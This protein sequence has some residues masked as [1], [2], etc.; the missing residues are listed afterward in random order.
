LRLVVNRGLSFFGFL[1]LLALMLGLAVY[2][3]PAALAHA[4]YERS[5][6]AANATVPSGQS[7]AQ[8]QVWFTEDLEMRFSE[9]QVVD[10]NKQRVDTGSTRADPTDPRSMII[11]LKP[12]LP[13]GAYTV[14]YNNAS[15]EDG[16]VLKGNFSFLVGSGTLPTSTA[17][18]PLEQAEGG[19]TAGNENANPASITLRW[20]NYLAAAALLGA[21]VF[22][23]LIW[24]PAVNRAR[25]TKRMGPELAQANE[26]GLQ[27]VLRV[28]W[29]GLAAMTVG[30][31]AWWI[32]QAATLS[33]Q[34]LGQLFGLGGGSSGPAALADFLFNTRYGLIWFVRL[35]LLIGVL[36]ALTFM[37]RGD[38]R[39]TWLDFLPGLRQGRQNLLPAEEANQAV[40]PASP[41]TTGETIEEAAETGPQ[42]PL[43]ISL[44]TRRYLWWAG[45]LYGMALMLTTSLNSHAAAVADWGFW[46]AIASDWLHLLSTATWVGGL[47]AMSFALMVALPALR[48]GSGDRTR[49]LAS[50]IP[51]FSQVIIISVMVLLVTGTFNAALQLANVTDLFSTPYGLS[52]TLKITLLV[53]LLLLGA[54][55]LLVVSPR[56]RAFARSKKAGPQEGAGSIAAGMLGLK[57]RRAVWAEIVLTVLILLVTAFLTSSNPPK[58]LATNNVLYFQT[59]QGDL[60]IDLAIAPGTIGENTFEVRLTDAVTNQP[61]SDA[62]LV[63]LR[64][65]MQEMDMGLTNLELKPLNGLPGRYLGEGPALAMVGTWHADLLI[66]RNG[67]DDV[68]YLVTLNI[69]E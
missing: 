58:G 68:D 17:G 18:S 64:V 12:N 23:L 61:V 21:L 49:L 41:A 39:K 62:A 36:F 5:L 28:A 2:Q 63:D 35:F 44:E 67:K 53:P 6:P 34:D 60:K 51:A 11:S 24:R 38:G 19:S 27:N 42:G 56:M 30:W 8:V 50:L 66:Q 55:N 65:E 52:L 40:P 31:V 1:T 25:A 14:I 22:T 3:A 45:L 57:F 46:V 43:T 16:H 59:V 26:R 48:P 37:L 4:N 9:L 33:G 13:D 7:P 29:W 47:L 32:Y 69:K 10:Q 20:L 15:A 54:Y